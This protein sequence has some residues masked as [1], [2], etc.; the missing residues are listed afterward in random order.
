[1]VN[2]VIVEDDS[3]TGESVS[4]IDIGG[5]PL[6]KRQLEILKEVSIHSI[7]VAYNS[8]KSLNLKGLLDRNQD[9]LSIKLKFI[10][11]TEL[12]GLISETPGKFLLVGNNCFFDMNC[13]KNCINILRNS[14]S[15]CFVLGDL[16]LNLELNQQKFKVIKNVGGFFCCIE[17]LSDVKRTEDFLY[18]HLVSP[19]DSWL[20]KKIN[21]KI[22]IAITRKLAHHNIHP[23]QITVFNFFIGVSGAYLISKAS[24]LSVLFG[25]ILFL[26]SSVLDGC[27]GELARLKLQKS[28]LGGY[29]DVIT[30]N[31]VHWFLFVAITMNAVKKS[32][33]FPYFPFGIA[34][35]V[36]SITAFILSFVVTHVGPKSQGLLF[37]ESSLSAVTDKKELVD[38]LANRDFAYLLV[39]LAFFNRIEWF[40]LL[41]GPGSIVFAYLL[42]NSLKKKGIV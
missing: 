12:D 32:G 9:I 30:D 7:F 3:Y 27:D 17:S 28:R 24:Y 40:L 42:Y 14:D 11:T 29:L 6:I 26:L 36:G 38:K 1:M 18:S 31:V 10:P 19:T 22:S 25:T 21:R 34:L 15:R 8:N 23:N 37:S 5:L 16:E 33:L 41:G 35:L 4:V 20:T 39:V 2:V 13:I